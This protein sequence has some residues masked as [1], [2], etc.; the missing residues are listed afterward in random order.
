ML[1][2]RLLRLVSKLM[3]VTHWLCSVLWIWCKNILRDFDE[4]EFG[5][6]TT[7]DI[8]EL[9]AEL[10]DS[11]RAKFNIEQLSRHV[12]GI[13]RTNSVLYLLLLTLVKQPFA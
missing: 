1:G 2:N 4:D 10:D 7:L 11:A 5:P 9:K 3:K 12:V 8:D 13:N 6:D